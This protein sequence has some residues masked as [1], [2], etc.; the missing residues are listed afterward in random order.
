MLVKKVPWSS[1]IQKFVN[2]SKYHSNWL[3]TM[4]AK[5]LESMTVI[6][7]ISWYL[8]ALKVINLFLCMN[9]QHFF[10][11]LVHR[12]V[13]LM[14]KYHIWQIF[15]CQGH[16][17]KCIVICSV[18]SYWSIT[19]LILFEAMLYL[20]QYWPKFTKPCGVIKLTHCGIVTPYGDRDLGHHRLRWWLV[21]WRHQAIT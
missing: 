14:V 2:A 6:S 18:W 20:N 17:Q 5:N 9:W 11:Q 19:E 8:E 1:W 15:L 10:N 16:L 3:E 21:A 7:L 13:T 4:N 12:K